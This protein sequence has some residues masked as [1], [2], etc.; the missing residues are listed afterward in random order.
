MRPSNFFKRLLF[1]T[2]CL[3]AAS[4]SSLSVADDA[5]LEAVRLKIS[6]TFEEIE[7]HHISASPIDGW[8]TVQKGS[9]VAYVSADGRYLLQG[10]LIDLDRET[11]LS[12]LAR[13]D[14]RRKLMSR[15]GDDGVI[16]FT[17]ANVEHSVTVFTDVD[18]TFCRRLHSQIDEYL[19]NGIEIRYILYPRNGPT[20]K[21]WDIAEN[22]WCSPDRNNAL[23]LAKLDREF[24]SEQ[25]GSSGVIKDNYALGHDV[26]LSGTPA[27]V[28]ADGSY[29]SGYVPP[30]VLKS[31]LD[32]LASR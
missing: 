20:S 15:A 10:D 27:F 8:Y 2:V 29:H 11:N 22:V 6:K 21:S 32:K 16:A 30:D 12:E 14:S 3:T 17:P 1:A 19:A 24:E 28:F 4:A 26:G 13:L 5:A 7:P 18:C 9:I 31:H 25:C 23:T